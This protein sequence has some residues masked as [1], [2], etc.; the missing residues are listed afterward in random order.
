MELG[1]P[2]PKRKQ[3]L[4][5]L[6]GEKSDRTF[7]VPFQGQQQ[8]FEI[9]RVSLG[10]P[11]YRLENGRTTGAQAEYIATHPA[12]PDDFFRADNEL[13]TAQKAQH[14]I[15][16]EL[17]KDSKNLFK[18]FEDNAQSE[19]IIL[20]SAGY[21][22]N[23]NRRLSTWR[24]L[25]EKEPAKYK[26]FSNIEVV[27]LPHADDREL[28]RLEADLQLKEDLKAEYSW[29]SKALMLKE[30]INRYNYSED[31]IASIYEMS[32]KDLRELF[33]SI[34]YGEQYLEIRNKPKQYSELKE[35]EFAFRA[36]S[37][38][39][40]KL[41]SG[42]DIEL[43]EMA[44]FC[45]TDEATEGSRI[46]AEIPRVADHLEEV[47]GNLVGELGLKTTN[48]TTEDV[49]LQLV[50]ALAELANLDKA[51]LAIRDTIEAEAAKKKSKKKQD[52]V[53][54]QIDK[55]KFCLIDARN[56]I[57]PQS[58]KNGVVDSLDQIAALVTELRKW[59]ASDDQ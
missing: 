43:F 57:E 28:D 5:D 58:A 4:K 40:T 10:L 34:D 38:G 7:L 25:Y 1:W 37:R 44:A 11:L 59:A 30:K 17:A 22:V 50:D 45:L 56:A 26:R 31:E 9:H 54:A 15:L 3:F 39:R 6:S 46:Y 41:K 19:P 8:H 12:T 32:K 27:I 55:A 16:V 24:E 35:K 18:E 23:G 13:E 53:A 20:S 48:L 52:Q 47:R 2:L 21:V 51:R 36:I 42:S 49:S 14:K 33:D 29:A